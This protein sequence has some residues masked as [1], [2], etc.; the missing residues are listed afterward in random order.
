MTSHKKVAYMILLLSLTVSSV[1]P[2]QAQ[3]R[4]TTITP[5]PTYT[6]RPEAVNRPRNVQPENRPYNNVQTGSHSS[7][8]LTQFNGGWY[9]N[10]DKGNFSLMGPIPGNWALA[11][12]SLYVDVGDDGNYYLYDAQFPNVAVQLTFVQNIGDDQAADD[13]D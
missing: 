13:Q 5:M 11:T 6:R 8:G 9:F 3:Q 4:R 2:I 7:P 12:D 10:S 1:G